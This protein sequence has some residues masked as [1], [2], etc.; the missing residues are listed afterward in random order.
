[1][2]KFILRRIVKSIPVL[3]FVIVI[4]FFITHLMPGDP[5]KTMLGDKASPD[6]I[7]SM[8]SQLN[9]DKPIFEQ[10][11]IWVSKIIRFDFGESI[12]WKES[13]VQ[14]MIKRIE[15]TF[16]LAV[17]AIFTSVLIGIPMGL[18]ASKYHNRIFDKL[19]SVG[20]LLS[21]SIPGFWLAIIAIQVFCVKINLFPVSG[22]HPV[23]EVGL[24]RSLYELL[25]P[26][27]VLG[28]MYSGQIARMTRM[29]MLDIMQSD[30]LRTAR[31][32]GL[33]ESLVLNVHGFINAISPIVLV[34][35]FC[36]A[37]LLGGSAVIEQLFNIPGIGNLMI[38]AVLNRDYPLIQASL[39][40]ISVIFILIN[41]IT[42]IICII[43]NPKERLD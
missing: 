18:T 1:M 17:I 13:I 24:I 26:G 31:A 11:T 3:I 19:F 12:F 36:F 2:F 6:Q 34:V 28:V 42:D 38:N 25:L 7:I 41:M 8:R 30:Y 16:L 14:I 15:P 5:I 22:Y 33:K 23:G 4:S 20:S 32:K 39:L 9:L 37:S 10:F 29:T 21:I 43:L 35:G 27:L 40:F